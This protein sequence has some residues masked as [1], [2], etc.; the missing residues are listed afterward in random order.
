MFEVVLEVQFFGQQYLAGFQ[1]FLVFGNDIEIPPKT[2][3][4]EPVFLA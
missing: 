4:N 1:C 2:L 3:T